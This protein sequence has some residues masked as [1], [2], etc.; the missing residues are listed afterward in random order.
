M[1]N[2]RVS[3]REYREGW[4]SV[5]AGQAGGLLHFKAGSA[6]ERAESSRV[7]RS[8]AAEVGEE[9]GSGIG[10]LNCAGPVVDQ[11][12][13]S[14]R[15]TVS[16]ART[17]VALFIHRAVRPLTPPRVGPRGRLAKAASWRGRVGG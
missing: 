12:N 7:Q 6:T 16:V 4:R 2:A 11:P 5:A 1:G 3:R 10:E 17:Y 9:V 14:G 8:D 13:W 15:L